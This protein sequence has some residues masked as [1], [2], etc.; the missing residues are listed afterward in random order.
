[1]EVAVVVEAAVVLAV[2]LRKK[3]QAFAYCYI[4]IYVRSNYASFL[5]L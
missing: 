4:D 3:C 5:V 1:L 2:M